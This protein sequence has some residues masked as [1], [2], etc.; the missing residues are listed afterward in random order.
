MPSRP[1]PWRAW[2][3]PLLVLLAVPLLPALGAALLHP[4]KPAW[5][6]PPLSEGEVLLTEVQR[7]PAGSFLWVDARSDQAFAE[8]HVPGALPLNESRWSD[9]LFQNLE[10]FTAGHRLLIYCD[11]RQ[12]DASKS[13]RQRL[14]KEKIATDIYVL[15]GGWQ[16]LENSAYTR[17]EGAGK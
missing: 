4:R 12:C 16:V 10:T 5:S 13:V 6:L 11:S 14:L 17:E 2:G 8:G 9:L 15:H 7:W 3:L 1:T